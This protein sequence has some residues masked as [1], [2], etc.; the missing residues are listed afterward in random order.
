MFD[1]G[2]F[3]GLYL[4]EKTISDDK[5]MKYELLENKIFNDI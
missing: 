3:G 4:P 1:D 2:I 5:L